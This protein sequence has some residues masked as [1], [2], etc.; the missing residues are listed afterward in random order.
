MRIVAGEH[1]GHRLESPSGKDV[2]PTSGLARESLFNVLSHGK[3]A[4]DGNPLSDANVLD[5][6]AG[7]GAN[8][9][10]ALSRGAAHAYFI[11]SHKPALSVLR[12][13]I[14]SLGESGRATVLTANVLYPPRARAACDLVI[15][16]PPYNET[17]AGEALGALKAAGWIAEGA[18]IA[19][20][21]AKTSDLDAPEGFE[22]LDTR[23]YG[24]AKIAFLTTVGG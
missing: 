19:V 10:E 21:L 6:F 9:L 14:Q 3:F 1:R 18:L 13:N 17:V 7:S 11:E 16:D 5:A 20:E 2:R 23:T 15:L 8:G 22:T 24:K 12:T 4:A